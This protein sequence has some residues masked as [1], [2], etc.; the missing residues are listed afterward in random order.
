MWTHLGLNATFAFGD[1]HENGEESSF[2]LFEQLINVDDLPNLTQS[3][4]H[5]MY[6]LVQNATEVRVNE[7]LQLTV[8]TSDYCDWAQCAWMKDSTWLHNCQA[9]VIR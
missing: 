3:P 2:K 9:P 1:D 8:R 5:L 7:L 6:E 4:Y